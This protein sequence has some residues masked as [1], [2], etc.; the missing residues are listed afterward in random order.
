MN[1]QN[2]N[3]D[4][5]EP[6]QARR[7]YLV[8]LAD[9]RT[10][11]NHS[12]VTLGAPQVEEAGDSDG[13]FNPNHNRNS[14]CNGYA[15]SRPASPSP[16]LTVVPFAPTPPSQ[17]SASE[18]ELH[19]SDRLFGRPLVAQVAQATYAAPIVVPGP[20]RRV[21]DLPFSSSQHYSYHPQQQQQQQQQQPQ[22][23][24]QPQQPDWEATT[25]AT[26]LTD[27]RDELAR[28]AGVVTPGVDDTPYIQY[29]IEALTR[30]R[31]TGYSANA[32][33]SSEEGRQRAPDALRFVPD[34]GLGYYPNPQRA[35][36]QPYNYPPQAPAS[37]PVPVPVPVP[38]PLPTLPVA[39]HVSDEQ[40]RLRPLERSR[41][42]PR[43]SAD[44]VASTLVKAGQRP[45]QPFEWRSL[46]GPDADGLP[47]LTFR[48]RVLRTAALVTLMIL[49]LLMIA[50]LM[51]CAV[52]SELH[53]SLCNYVGI[54]GGRYF[55]FRMLPQLLAAVLLLYSQLVMA[56]ISR[57]TPFVRLASEEREERA[58]SLFQ[59]LYLRTF[60]WPRLAGTWDMWMPAL[61]TWLANF[62]LPLQSSLF[63]VVY[64]GDG[65]WRWATVQGVAWTLVALY[66]A[67]LVSTAVV[68]R[69]WAG[70][71]TTGLLWD[72][73]CLADII[74]MVSDTN[75]ADDYRGTQ[76]AGTR[77]G[78]RFA[79]RRRADDKLGY[80]TWRDGRPGFWYAIGNTMENTS[81]VPF[82]DQLTGKGMERFQAAKAPAVV[83]GPDGG[84]YAAEPDQIDLEDAAR[85]S[86]Q[87][88]YRYLPWC[89]RDSQLLFFA[90][91][92]FVLLLALFLVSFLPS[93][94][95]TGGFLPLLSS[96]P[97]PGAFSPADF[98]YSFLP[99]LLGTVMFLLF[100]SLD[101]NL[102]IL[103]PWAALSDPR[104]GGARAEHSLLADY[105]ACA[106]IQSTLH[107][108]R[109]RHWRVAVTSFLSTLFVL[110]PILAGGM[111]MALTPRDGQVRM[112]PN[113][114]AFAVVLTLL[115]LYFLALVSMLPARSAF[116]LPH[117]VTCLA[118]IISFLVNDDLLNDLTF[119]QVIGGAEEQGREAMLAK[120]GLHH[121]T[122]ETQPRWVFGFGL[123]S[124]LSGA[125]VEDTQN[126]LGVRQARKFTEKRKVRKSQIRRGTPH[127]IL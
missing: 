41:T 13:S 19:G 17:A 60:L 107:A 94:R 63:T 58:G 90:A 12:E 50:A 99:S 2:L 35:P 86:Q 21:L 91:A 70:M 15:S 106:P 109:N 126:T 39:A 105:A 111:F 9:P 31:D 43:A 24:P 33:S 40:S 6:Q 48:P 59:D 57:I 67:L 103:Q 25:N 119:K 5:V 34:Q 89:L 110:I 97:G 53:G 29:A 76:M 26:M 51:F 30:D 121:G 82:P 115:V 123:N 96:A 66:L 22:L 55:L 79:L 7:P 11:S 117:A 49:V 80:W 65:V 120:M 127:P 84:Y 95:V 108:L 16:P 10:P 36:Q 62:T 100:Q 54:Y 72:P 125:G 116:R 27:F 52:Y 56:A 69:Y 104:R 23:Q 44:S 71:Q 113:V 114:P 28:T 8:H 18:S 1:F 74:V 32:S 77:D 101:M 45:A 75:T 20:R 64:V 47:R 3:P 68:W 124:E 4:H 83:R 102:R 122:P 78:I 112:F 46:S 85:S 98:L 73:T 87:A 42:H 92:A 38:V 14:D 118:E 88:R 81:H 93:T 37:G 61:A